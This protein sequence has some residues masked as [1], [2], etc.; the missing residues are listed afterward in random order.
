VLDGQRDFDFEF[1]CWRTTVSR[2]KR[3][4]SGET[5]WLKYEGTSIVYPLL[6]GSAN[7]VELSIDGP[8]GS[9]KGV[10]LRLFHPKTRQWSL[11][12]A[13][14]AE[15]ELTKPLSGRFNG[16]RGEFYGDD[17]F[18]GRA[19]RVRFVISDIKPTL[20]KFEQAFS[21]DGGKSWEI[22][23]I[24][25]DTRLGS[26]SDPAD[27]RKHLPTD[28]PK[29]QVA[30]IPQSILPIASECRAQPFVMRPHSN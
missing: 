9:I 20:V 29:D 15:G 6:G 1:G 3:P 16:T 5:E 18:A 4:L 28:F 17:D 11:H 24:A 7:L 10:S 30:S 2:L 27:C 12:Y 22:N 13:S 23:W 26:S 19:I 25:N 8:T 14:T 21:V